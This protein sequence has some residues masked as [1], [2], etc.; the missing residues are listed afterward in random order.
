MRKSPTYVLFSAV[1]ALISL[2]ACAPAKSPALVATATATTQPTTSSPAQANA[3]GCR[4]ES[5]LIPT[6][7]ATQVSQYPAVSKSDWSEGP[8]DASVTF[9]EYGDYQ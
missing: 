7:D 5:S 6:P 2:A 8:E 3:A 9:I 4:V 1:L